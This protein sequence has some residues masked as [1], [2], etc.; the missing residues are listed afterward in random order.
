M[1]GHA[2][3]EIE[4]PHLIGGEDE[5]RLKPRFRGRVEVTDRL[6][7]VMRAAIHDLCVAMESVGGDVVQ[8]AA[9]VH[10]HELDRLALLHRDLR[11]LV[12]ELGHHDVDRPIHIDGR[13]LIMTLPI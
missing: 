9:L 3:E 5:L 6:I 1:S 8:H 10:Q 7:V 11:W 2:A 12:G 13:R 4:F